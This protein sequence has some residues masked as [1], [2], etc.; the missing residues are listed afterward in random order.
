MI[1]IRHDV[2]T[3]T[4]LALLAGKG[5]DASVVRYLAPMT[6]TSQGT[7]LPTFALL[8]AA[9]DTALPATRRP[10][11]AQTSARPGS[12]RPSINNPSVEIDGNLGFRSWSQPG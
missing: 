10:R 8:G 12:A 9:K 5:L 11:A 7:S 1:S 6:M 3:A 2:M 4:G